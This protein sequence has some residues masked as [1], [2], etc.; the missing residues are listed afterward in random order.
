MPK[1]AAP[2]AAFMR[3]ALLLLFV[4]LV[5]VAPSPAAAA[6]ATAAVGIVEHV[7]TGEAGEPC[8]ELTPFE[9]AID[10]TYTRTGVAVTKPRPA[11]APG[12]LGILQV[13]GAGQCAVDDA[14]TLACAAGDAFAGSTLAITA[15]GALDMEAWYGYVHH[16][17][18]GTVA[19]TGTVAP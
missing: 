2:A 15:A 3:R 5:L 7:V 17:L 16:T 4:A 10:W 18:R 11:G 19:Y 9:L 12:C 8:V 13:Y 14:G 1:R 6:P